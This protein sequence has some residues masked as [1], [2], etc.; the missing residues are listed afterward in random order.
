MI[1]G[2]LIVG[3]LLLMPGGAR[4][5]GVAGGAAEPEK[6]VHPVADKRARRAP[7]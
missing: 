2:F 3:S 7:A 1:T 4:L 6:C 5:R